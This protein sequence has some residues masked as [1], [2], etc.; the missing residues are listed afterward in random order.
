MDLGC[1]GVG[2]QPPAGSGPH[3]IPGGQEG[4][5]AAGRAGRRRGQRQDQTTV[6]QLGCRSQIYQGPGTTGST[7]GAAV[8]IQPGKRQDQLEEEEESQGS[9]EE[10]AEGADRKSVV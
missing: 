10:E 1:G 7:A 4:E 8:P 3:C 9:R 6:C 2:H 5:A